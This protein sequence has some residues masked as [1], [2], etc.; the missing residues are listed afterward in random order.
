MMMRETNRNI[1]E[2]IQDM[3]SGDITKIRYASCEICSLSQNHEKIMELIP[4]QAQMMKATKNINL[5]GLLAPNNRF[6]KKAFEIMDFYKQ[7]Q[8]CCPCCILG[9][10]DN[11]LYLI[12]QGYFTLIDTVY[13]KDRQ[14]IDY[15]IIDCN[16]CQNRYQV[17]MREYHYIW[18]NWTLLQTK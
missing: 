7:N 12:A 1:T 5:G 8:Y 18:W 9:E 11:P 10:D 17:E 3:L 13:V 2:V 6:L 16:R 14:Y 4:Y 15:Y